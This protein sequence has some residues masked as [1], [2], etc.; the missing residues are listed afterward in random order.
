VKRS[1]GA[2]ASA[3]LAGASL[4]ACIAPD[5]EVIGALGVTVDDAGRPVLVVEACDGAATLVTLSFNREG[6][7]DDEENE[8]I[9]SWTSTEPAAGRSEL[10]LHAPSAPWQGESIDLSVERGYVAGGK[11]EGNKQV[12]TQ[13]AFR[14]SQFAEMESGTIYR[15]DH[16][17]DVTRLVA[18]NPTDFSAE[19][20]R[21]G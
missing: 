20:C 1:V 13:V 19:V 9:A 7:T 6:L 15:N 11:G 17:L 2:A 16:N 4:S 5:V 10:P 12:L 3:V 21:G 8:D 18:V 14:G